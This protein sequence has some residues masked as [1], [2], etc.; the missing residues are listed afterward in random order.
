MKRRMSNLRGFQHLNRKIERFN[1]NI[2]RIKSVFW[3]FSKEVC[4]VSRSDTVRNPQACVCVC[5]CVRVPACVGVLARSSFFTQTKILQVCLIRNS[6]SS[7]FTDIIGRFC[8]GL[9]LKSKPEASLD[10]SCDSTGGITLW[11]AGIP[12]ISQRAGTQRKVLV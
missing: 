5:V 4:V 9:W 12:I 11:S 8:C 2:Q 3:P 7:H 1:G 6:N 10:I